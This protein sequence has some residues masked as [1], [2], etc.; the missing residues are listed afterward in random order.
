MVNTSYENHNG[1][2]PRIVAFIC[3][4]GAYAAAEMAG[5]GR[6]QYPPN[7]RLVRLMCL[8]QL[9]LSQIIAAFELGADGVI[10]LGCP[11]GEC[12][13]GFGSRRAEQTFNEAKELAETV[14][15]EEGRL[16]LEWIPPADGALFAQALTEFAEAVREV[17]RNPLVAEAVS[18]QPSR[19]L[20]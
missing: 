5:I 18:G 20:W 19:G 17:G 8:G 14:G 2:E 11:P 15:L 6:L 1:H 16:R 13:Y 12:H 4:W 7:I 3:N 10:L 9:H